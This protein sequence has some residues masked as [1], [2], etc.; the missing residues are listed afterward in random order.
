[1]SDA[2]LIPLDDY[3]P[4]REAPLVLDDAQRAEFLALIAEGER[5]RSAAQSVGVR[6][7]AVRAT[8]DG[9]ALFA[10]SYEEARAEALERVEAVL[11]DMALNRNIRAIETWLQNQAPEA[12]GQRSLHV[13]TGPGG[14]PIQHVHG[15]VHALRELL[16]DESTREKMVAHVSELPAAPPG[17]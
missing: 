7:G 2:H 15:V 9:D 5:P 11:Y 10:E 8:M 4:V 1:M 17:R 6:W 12:W 3:V 13:H 14:G 16:L